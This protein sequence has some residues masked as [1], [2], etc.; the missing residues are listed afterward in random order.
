MFDPRLEDLKR[1]SS[2]Y[3]TTRIASQL[4]YAHQLSR[5]AA[6]AHDRLI[7]ETIAA[8]AERCGEEPITKAA[9]LSAEAQLASLSAEAKRYR[10]TC[11]GHAHID[12]NWMWRFDETVQVCLDTF[13]TVLNL[14]RDFPDFKFSQSQAA[15][16]RIVEDYAPD[17]LDEIRARVKE[18]RWEITASTW[19]EADKN[20]PSG[21][22]MA[23]HIL[24]T[25][26]YLSRLFE[27]DPDSLTLDFEP[28]TFGHSLNVPEILSD[29]GIKY[30]YHCRGDEGENLYRW[31]AP[32]GRSVLSYRDPFWY[33]GSV[34]PAM[35]LYVPDFCRR[36]GMT[37]MLKVYGVGDHGGGPT[38]RDL[39]RITDM[40]AWP[41][42]PSICFGSFA[43]YFAEVEQVAAQLPEVRGE[44]NPIF[45]G[46]YTSQTRIKRANHL[47]E[48]TLHEAEAFGA[49][50]AQ[51]A[52]RQYPGP[53]LARA[54][55]NTLFNQFHDIIP[56]SGTVDTREYAL[57][58]FQQTMAVAG[59][60]RARALQA[61]AQRVDTARLVAPT[62]RAVAPG[63]G[64]IAE[65]AG[66]GAGIDDY[67]VTQSSHAG[68]MSRVFHVFNPS[69]VTR[70][71]PAELV[72]WDWNG[73]LKRLTCRDEQDHVVSHQ[74]LEGGWHAYW[75]HQ[76]LR[77]L[78]EATVPAG[79][80][81]TYTIREASDVSSAWDFPRDPRVEESDQ[82]VLENE[83]L[84]AEFD[85]GNFAI[86]ALLDK[87]S[88]ETLVDRTRPGAFFRYIEEDDRRGMT[89]W[90]VGRHM[91]TRSLAGDARLLAVQRGELRQSVTYETQF[92]NRSRLTVTV[93]LDAGSHRLDI[94][95]ECDW[96]ETG[97]KGEGVPQLS[98][99][100]PCA[101]G[102]PAYRYDVPFGA[103][104]RRPAHMDL[105]ATSWAQAVRTDGG[106]SS[107]ALITQGTHGFR[108]VDDALSA[109]LIRSSYDP[110][111]YP[112]LGI[113]KIQLGVLVC[114]AQAPI[115]R[116]I[117]EADHCSHPLS[118]ISG[119]VHP[120]DLPA[121]A[122]FMAIESGSV[123]LSAVKL[124]EDRGDANTLIVRVYETEGQETGATLRF[125]RPVV[126]ARVLDVNERPLPDPANA[127]RVDGEQVTLA[128]GPNRVAT[129]EVT[130]QGPDLANEKQV[131][132]LSGAVR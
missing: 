48:S 36:Y 127:P 66:A 56:G 67:R 132:D 11:A 128:V 84:R 16:Y 50:A 125:F 94:A 86:V 55:Q 80:Y 82:L 45:T 95:A 129:L 89:A 117:Q 130:L 32:S 41:V 24:Y 76:Y 81:S 21:E 13:R 9:A 88:D 14:M 78:V 107:L 61:I 7:G 47:A 22:S 112:E 98:F 30:Y 121:C 28:D 101:F 114:E 73:D 59:S 19:V 40:N 83:Y 54:W 12:M 74:I 42:F 34:E 110:D 8:L 124:P 18:G 51:V 1:A 15:V 126:A 72:L 100:L 103:L 5:L 65:G 33:L 60:Q 120:G 38:R 106:R 58:L 27:L 91:A 90:T 52:D 2:S 113:H 131:R 25:R 23:R 37:T 68:D 123:A 119:N 97:R 49:W 6:G 39:E 109:T 17:M 4:E 3:W 63:Q 53:A 29:G 92:G 46:C 75:G 71:E 104:V 85:P 57:G 99:Y 77:L 10:L 116:L 96:Q 79:G 20:M 31:I 105:P 122:G 87:T 70:R 93:A 43:G 64:D 69:P 111:P 35:A 115:A 26:R 44:L 108:G 118:V 62:G 102:A